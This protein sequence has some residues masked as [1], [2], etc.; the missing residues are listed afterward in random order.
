MKERKTN[1]IAGATTF[2]M[3][4]ILSVGLVL[5]AL[6][7][8]DTTTVV[9]A[10]DAIFTEITTEV[11][12]PVTT[13]NETVTTTTTT[14]VTTTATTTVITTTPTITESSI[15]ETTTIETVVETGTP[16][17]GYGSDTYLLAY[18]M[19]REAEY[20]NFTDA[21]YVGNVII[22]RLAD[23]DYPNTIIDVLQQPG[24]YPWA[25]YENTYSAERIYDP[26]FYTI[27]ELL[28]SGQ[29]YLPENVVFQSGEI[30]GSGVC[31]VVGSTLYC[32]K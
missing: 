24:Q 10:D 12:T 7:P 11:E 16:Q 5:T 23:S 21:A 19:A 4:A 18:A 6:E 28:L 27:A 17:Y 13:I 2:I 15:T 22:N 8:I 3:T 25:T 9:V 14:T 29:R 20:A 32:Y 1:I 30:Q 31:C 26:Q